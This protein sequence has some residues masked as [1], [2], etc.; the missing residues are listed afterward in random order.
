V[1]APATPYDA[2]GLLISAF[3]DGNPVVYLEHKALYRSARGPVPGGRYMVPI[4]AARL[5]RPGRHA[6]VVTY[7][8]GVL[9][10]LDAAEKLAAEGVEIEVVDLRTLQPW[11]VETVL[12]S[13]RKTSR[14]LVLHEA[15]LTGGFGGEVAATIASQAFEWLDAPVQR[16][17]S[18][19]TPVPFSKKLE[20]LFMP[21][22]RLLDSLRSLV[23]Y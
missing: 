2:K 18:L 3:F 6:T 15:P 11:D 17:A 8:V 21:K 13:V 14:A 20:E 10:A 23:A 1:V 5:A 7:G 12:A 4:G 9:W 16:L 22:A 19:D